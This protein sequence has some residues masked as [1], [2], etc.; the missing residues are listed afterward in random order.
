MRV[1]GLILSILCLLAAMGILVVGYDVT[2]GEDT[3]FWENVRWFSL[4]LALALGS[5]LLPL[6]AV[7]RGWR[8]SPLSRPFS[9]S[10]FGLSILYTAI[11]AI[12]VAQWAQRAD[13]HPIFLVPT[14]M[15][16]GSVFAMKTF[17][18]QAR[19]TAPKLAP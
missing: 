13:F 12:A 8:G 10:L 3:K 14:V 16:L 17:F 5:F 7:L 4:Y 9:W 6:I 19:R 2:F 15:L 1:I 11:W 18:A